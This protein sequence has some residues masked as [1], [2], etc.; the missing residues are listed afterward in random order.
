MK[1]MNKETCGVPDSE[2]INRRTVLQGTA[3]TL[4]GASAMWLSGSS[5][6]DDMTADIWPQWQR[7]WRRME[8][9]ALKRGWELTP[10]RIF[11]PATSAALSRVEA[12]HGLTFPAQLREVL[13][14]YAARVQFRW[15][16]PPHLRSLEKVNMPNISGLSLSIWD[17][18][19]IDKYAIPNFF[20]WNKRNQ[21]KDISE[22]PNR[23]E[24]WENQFPFASL[25]NGDMLTIDVSNATGP[26]PVRYFS[27][28]TD[29]LHGKAIAPDFISF[30]T[31]YAALGCAGAED[32]DWFRFVQSSDGDKRYLR[33]TGDGARAWLAWLVKDPNDVG[34]DEPP[35]AIVETSPADRALLQAARAN[36]AVAVTAALAAGAKIDCVPNLDWLLDE[37]IWD[38][39]EEFSTAV[40]FAARHNN[41]YM[42]DLLMKCGATL[43][44]WQLPL[45]VAV[46]HSSLEVVQWL[47]AHGARVNGWKDE[48]H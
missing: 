22:E 19:E 48:R 37:N 43:N 16:V 26:Q 18:D 28:E 15:V 27:H 42:L 2:L 20:G 24:M 41:I 23:P 4:A 35:P 7:D 6:A 36:S 12:K 46:E 44:T 45:T 3:A 10:L 21:T 34:P 30:M 25:V 17:L 29:G 14:Q 31:V 40:T 38:R 39:P 47:I 32:H 8:A 33:S 5:K 1:S 11:L 13:T 9:I